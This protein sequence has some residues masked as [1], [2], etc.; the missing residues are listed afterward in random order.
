MA[1]DFDADISFMGHNQAQYIFAQYGLHSLVP[2]NVL[3]F[4]SVP[5]LHRSDTHNCERQKP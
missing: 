1:I 3:P 5:E 4:K 2:L